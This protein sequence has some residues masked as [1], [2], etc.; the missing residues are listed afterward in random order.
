MD[1]W[2]SA[3]VLQP[4]GHSYT[5]QQWSHPWNRAGVII[6]GAPHEL[7]SYGETVCM[8]N[9]ASTPFS[10][11]LAPTTYSFAYHT[12]YCLSRTILHCWAVFWKF[13]CP[14]MFSPHSSSSVDLPVDPTPAWFMPLHLALSSLLFM[15]QPLTSTTSSCKSLK[16]ELQ[17]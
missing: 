12:W 6:S 14:L 13:A 5:S 16:L 8:W 1:S 17:F 3:R 11:S 2:Y 15:P 10:Q 9:P 7:R 4:F